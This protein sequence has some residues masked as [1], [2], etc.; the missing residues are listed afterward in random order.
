MV[1]KYKVNL[2]RIQ[3]L[4]KITVPGK[5]AVLSVIALRTI[6]L[7]NLLGSPNNDLFTSRAYNPFSA[8]A[9]A[10]V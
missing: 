4:S 9:P 1:G 7:D 6:G 8:D 5:Q 2:Y 10:W 3:L